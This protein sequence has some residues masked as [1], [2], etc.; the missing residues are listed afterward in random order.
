LA[1]FRDDGVLE[2]YPAGT[3]GNVAPTP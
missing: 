1:D 3:P 2:S